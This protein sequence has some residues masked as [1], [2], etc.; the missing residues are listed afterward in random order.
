MDITYL[1]HSCFKLKAKD[2]FSG[3][4][5]SLLFDPFDPS[6]VGLPFAKTEADIV[7]VSHQHADHNYLDKI[8]QGYF[9]IDQ[10]GEYEVRG[11]S[12]LGYKVDHD[13][14]KGEKR[15]K[16]NIFV[17]EAEGCR[18]AHLGDLGRQL[19]DHEL[20]D[21]GVIDVLF[22]PVGGEYTLDQKEARDL[23][24]KISPTIAIPM[25]F[26]QKGLDEKN[27]IDLK[28]LESFLGMCQGLKQEVMDKYSV[29]KCRTEGVEPSIVI[30]QRK[31]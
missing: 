13:Q 11:I 30:L 25:H 15:G 16:N 31:G 18:I 28:T 4:P 2:G 10:P 20:S 14:E 3:K 21:L 6:F 8:A 9:L 17:V 12:V 26:M 5:I 19:T 24:S 7:T 1:G 29:A 22:L 23:I 27:F